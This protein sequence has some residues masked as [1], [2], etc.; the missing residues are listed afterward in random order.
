[1]SS[2]CCASVI[3]SLALVLLSCKQ[4]SA[5]KADPAAAAAEAAALADKAKLAAASQ[6]PPAAPPAAGKGNLAGIVHHAGA[7]AAG[8]EVQLCEEFST[9][10]LGSDCRG[11]IVKVKTDEHGRYLFRDLEPKTYGAI[12]VRAFETPFYQYVTSLNDVLGATK[13]EVRAGA[14]ETANSVDLIKRDLFVVGPCFLAR[15]AASPVVRWMPVPGATSYRVV[16]TGEGQVAPRFDDLAKG[17]VG[18]E[19]SGT[20]FTPSAA[21]AP[22]RWS[23]AVVA[24]GGHGKPSVIAISSERCEFVVPGAND[25]TPISDAVERTPP[26]ARPA[27]PALA[28]LTPPPGAG[29]VQGVVLF[30]E[31]PAA[32]LEVK[33]CET[34]DQFNGCD[35]KTLKTKT[36]ARGVY[37]FGDVPPM[38]WQGLTVRVFNTKLE[39]F[40]R[41]GLL[42]NAAYVVAPDRVLSVPPM[43]MFKTDL[44]VSSPRER[45]KLKT[46]QFEV[47]WVPYPGAASYKLDIDADGYRGLELVGASFVL[48]K[49]IANGSYELE[50]TALDAWGE[51]LAKTARPIKFSIAAAD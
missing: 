18:S 3:A 12:T 26:R 40:V 15:V 36:D 14:T 34:F 30:A 27:I 9:I 37:T 49:P 51:P 13:H 24:L 33:L 16:L 25:K 22:G 48:D 8:V 21:L 5:P 7:P 17:K 20:S 10:G 6:P 29:A 28:P 35:G 4:D 2:I 41:S 46:R 1:M 23:I 32:G 42:T 31:Q 50:L 38:K 47:K 39:L 43:R 44:R 45:A 19:A 11:Q